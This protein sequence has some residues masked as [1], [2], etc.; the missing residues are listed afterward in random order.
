MSLECLAA[1]SYLMLG[2]A[3]RTRPQSLRRKH[4]SA[5]AW[6]SDFWLPDCE[7]MRLLFQAAVL[8]QRFVT[9]TL[10]HRSRTFLQANT[11]PLSLPD[12]STPVPL[13][14]VLF[15]SCLSSRC[16]VLSHRP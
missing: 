11:S 7:R 12:W 8:V 14:P 2:E 10:G 9:A 3:G 15:L 13:H 6:V 5:S 16:S 4:G 1:P